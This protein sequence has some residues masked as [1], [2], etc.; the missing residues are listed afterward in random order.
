MGEEGIRLLELREREINEM[1]SHLRNMLKV[2]EHRAKTHKTSS[3]HIVITRPPVMRQNEPYLKPAPRRSL[4][5]RLNERKRSVRSSSTVER[6][7]PQ[8]KRKT[9]R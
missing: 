6:S 1:R 2:M 8:V 4:N 3:S 5:E 9:K 7:S